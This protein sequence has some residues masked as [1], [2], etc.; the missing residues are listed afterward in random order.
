MLSM[1]RTLVAVGMLVSLAACQTAYTG[2]MGFTGGVVAEPITQDVV[3]I[4]ARGNGFTSRTRVQDFV[5]LKAAETTLASGRTHF[6]IGPSSDASRMGVISTPSTFQAQRIG[7]TVYGSYDPG[8]T[9][10]YVK[11][12]QDTII[13]MISVPKGQNPPS[14][15]FNAAEIEAIIGPRLRTQ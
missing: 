1:T 3:R 9:D 6:L 11:P 2:G 13:Q 15:A 7:N 14:G 5:L 10:T 8:F 4:S 12:G